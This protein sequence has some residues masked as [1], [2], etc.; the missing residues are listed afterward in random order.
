MS[1]SEI[2]DF[3]NIKFLKYPVHRIEYTYMTGSIAEKLVSDILREEGIEV[4]PHNVNE[5]GV[6]I[7]AKDV[8]IGIEVWNWS[9]PHEYNSRVQSVLENL[10][11]FQFRALVTSFI[12]DTVKDNII[13]NYVISPVLII[14][15]GF[16]ILPKEFKD[17]Y[18]NRKD[19]VFYPSRQAYT[20]VKQ[21]LKPL[22]KRIKDIG[23]NRILNKH[24]PV[25]EF[26]DIDLYDAIGYN[27]QEFNNFLKDLEQ[28][29]ALITVQEPSIESPLN[30]LLSTKEPFFAYVYKNNLNLKNEDLEVRAENIEA[31]NNEART[32]EKT[33]SLT[34]NDN[35]DVEREQFLNETL[36]RYPSLKKNKIRSSKE[37]PNRKYKI[38]VCPLKVF[39]PRYMCPFRVFYLKRHQRFPSYIE[40]Y[41]KIYVCKNPECTGEICKTLDLTCSFLVEINK[42]PRMYKPP[43]FCLPLPKPKILPSPDLTYYL[44][45]KQNDVMK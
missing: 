43:H 30:K 28:H 6:D 38:L 1:Q 27:K 11:P 12:S 13:D 36:S 32:E 33:E 22:I 4:V 3:H 35:I 20:K 31:E 8:D 41:G 45:L 37:C 40:K 18:E 9:R 23:T 24:F 25:Y 19:V 16:Q 17:F 39:R 5:N 15:L 44:N 21:K 42:C 10:K 34:S 14:E 7:R 2:K 29:I 26:E